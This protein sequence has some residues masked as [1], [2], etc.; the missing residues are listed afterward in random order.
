MT[1]VPCAYCGSTQRESGFLAPGGGAP[2]YTGWIPGPLRLG[3]LGNARVAGK[4][5]WRVEAWRCAG[6]GRLEMFARETV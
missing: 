3:P 6:C 4:Q 2:R 1:N 5:K